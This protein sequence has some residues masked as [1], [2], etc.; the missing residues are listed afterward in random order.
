MPKQKKSESE[1]LS[2]VIIEGIL[3]KKGREVLRME[4]KKLPNA[5]SDYFVI[6]HANSGT[7]V[8]AI[9]ESVEEET[10]KELKAKP[11]HK[12]GIENAEWILIDY[13]NVVVHIFREE[14]RTFYN[15]EK[16]WG[17]APV[18]EFSDN[19]QTTDSGQKLQEKSRT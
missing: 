6:C 7:Q 1:K 12:E 9:A 10:L 15:L 19:L 3:K 5:V 18:K 2:E 8:K 17:D 11:W 16:L 13:V 14:S 4:L